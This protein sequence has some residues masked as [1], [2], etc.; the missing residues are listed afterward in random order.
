MLSRFWWITFDVSDL[1]PGGWQ[2]DV[3]AVAADADVRY[4]PKTPLLTREGTDVLSVERGRVHAGQVRQRLPWLYDL[5]HGAFRDLAEKAWRE[6]VKAARDDRYGVVLNVQRGTKMRFECHVDSNPLTGLLF[7]TDHHAGGEL[8]ISH[9]VD[10]HSVEGVDGNC[11]I[12]RPQAG[13]L[14]FFDV[15]RHPHYSRPLVSDSDVRILADMNFYT[16]SS[17]EERRPRALNH[18]LFGDPELRRSAHA[19]GAGRGSRD[20]GA[21]Q[22]RVA[23]V[24]HRRLAAGHP[25]GGRVQADLDGIAVWPGPAPVHLA[26][27]A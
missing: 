7:C 16:D 5:Y 18:Y 6:P 3:E 15:T 25:A 26:V 19:G 13:H 22:D 27:R 14:V 12:I 11:A 24:K 17:P 23:V 10:A 8:V 21:A 1:L 2:Q 20:G 9:D 4:F